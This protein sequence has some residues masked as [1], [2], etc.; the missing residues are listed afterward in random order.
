LQ[1]PIFFTT[2]VFFIAF[3]ILGLLISETI[4]LATIPSVAYSWIA[5]SLLLLFSGGVF[6]GNILAYFA[7]KAQLD[8]M[9]K[10]EGCAAHYR[11]TESVKSSMAGCNTFDKMRRNV[12]SI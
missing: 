12:S 4:T 7:V 10:Y 11:E 6:L 8:K 9:S 3:F 5:F 2:L 1:E